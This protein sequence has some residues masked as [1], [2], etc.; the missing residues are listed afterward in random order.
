M[1]VGTDR[2]GWQ[3]RGVKRVL[4]YTDC[5]RADFQKV[6]S[7]FSIFRCYNR[8]LQRLCS[9]EERENRGTRLLLGVQR[10][11]E[12]LRLRAALRA[13]PKIDG[14]ERIDFTYTG[15]G[16]YPRP[17]VSLHS[18]CTDVVCLYLYVCAVC[19]PSAYN[20]LSQSGLKE[21]HAHTPLA[22]NE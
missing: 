7:F 22:R 19:V 4:W 8:T 16:V 1:L 10:S 12:Y 15:I 6:A 13:D 17:C 9:I 2:E 18:T 21:L 20:I 14:Q 5:T 11:F 3:N